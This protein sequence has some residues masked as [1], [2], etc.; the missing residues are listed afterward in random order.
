MEFDF[1]RGRQGTCAKARQCKGKDLLDEIHF[2]DLK[3]DQFIEAVA[4]DRGLQ[5][6]DVRPM[7]T[8]RIFT[9]DQSL[10]WARGRCYERESVLVGG[11][12]V[13]MTM[14]IGI[15]KFVRRTK[16]PGQ[17]GD[18]NAKEQRMEGTFWG[19]L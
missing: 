6:D 4:H 13:W 18:Q 8:G 17:L 2:V 9:A 19:S 12:R 10:S 5:V 11:V 16:S 15:P 7:A 3:T 1:V 14:T